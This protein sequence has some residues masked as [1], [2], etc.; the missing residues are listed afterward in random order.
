MSLN[1]SKLNNRINLFLGNIFLL[2]VFFLNPVNGQGQDGYEG[3]IRA[4]PLKSGISYEAGK[5]RDPFKSLVK[6]ELL[7]SSG[8]D[9]AVVTEVT[10]PSLKIKGVFWGGDFPQAIINDKVVKVGDTIEGAQILS[11]D[12]NS[13]SVFFVNRQ[14]ILSSPASENLA[15]SPNEGKKEDVDE[16]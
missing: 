10:A 2:G 7:V 3:D 6:P 12:K 8:Q 1:M 14:F 5:L 4:I 9:G 15:N 13:V 16:N 11:I